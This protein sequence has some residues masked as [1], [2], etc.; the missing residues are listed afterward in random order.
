MYKQSWC[1][2]PGDHRYTSH[3]LQVLQLGLVVAQGTNALLRLRH[4]MGV[5]VQALVGFWPGADTASNGSAHWREGC[6]AG[7][8]AYTTPRLRDTVVDC[9]GGLLYGTPL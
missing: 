9:A 8:W 3:L 7:L 4:S 2:P 1:R 6:R 5:V